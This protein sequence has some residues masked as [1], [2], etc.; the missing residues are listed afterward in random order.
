MTF[1]TA[2]E[3]VKAY[4]TGRCDAY[5]TDA[6]RPLRRAPAADRSDDHIVLP[7]IIS[8]EPLAPAVRQGDDTWED[9]VRWTHEAMVDAEELGVTKEMSTI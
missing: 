4:D 3:A 5:T 2:D 9:I 6:S 1:A 8:K 7:E